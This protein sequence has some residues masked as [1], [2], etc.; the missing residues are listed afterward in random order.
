MG[1][2][3]FFSRRKRPNNG[4]REDQPR[5]D[6]YSFAHVVL[7]DAAFQNP[8]QFVTELASADPRERIASL[9]KSVEQICEQHNEPVSL[10]PEDILI[11]KVP[12]GPWPCALVE[13][14]A[15]ARKTEA[16][17]V[18]LVLKVDLS[19]EER[20]FEPEPLRF[21]TLEF[22][23][24]NAIDEVQTVLGEWNRDGSHELLGPGPEPDLEGFVTAIEKLLTSQRLD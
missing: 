23:D 14:P 5:C 1:L 9:W 16:F 21:L 17:F 10:E 12:I 6:H 7:R 22:A 18:A 24:T 20:R 2:F 19:R 11:H 8:V 15:A 4:D 13:L 3:D